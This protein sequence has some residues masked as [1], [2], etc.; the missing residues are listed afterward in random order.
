MLNWK[1]VVFSLWVIAFLGSSCGV[2][3]QLA[4]DETLV[5][6]TEV[7]LEKSTY[8]IKDK[9]LLKSELFSLIKQKPNKR[10]LLLFRTGVS[11]YYHTDE[12]QDT[13]NWKNFLRNNL[14]ETPAIYSEKITKTTTKSME[15]YLKQKGYFDAVVEA[16]EKHSY[17]HKETTVSYHVY[18]NKRYSIK[19]IKY[20][21]LDKKLEG[22]LKKLEQNTLL[23][24]GS[25]IDE[26]LYRREVQR[27]T[28]SLRNNGYVYFYP[29]Y[30]QALESDSTNGKT[31]L[32]IDLSVRAP[33]EEEHHQAYTIGK[34]QVYPTF[35]APDLLNYTKDTLIN[36]YLF[37]T[38]N[39]EFPIKP[40]VIID[41]IYLNPGALFRQSNYDKTT[42]QLSNLN[43]Y[44]FVNVKLQKD[45][46]QVG[47]ID[48]I[49][50]LSLAKKHLLGGNADLNNSYNNLTSAESTISY[51]GA[52]LNLNY[53]NRNT[54]GGA[55]MLVSSIEG[56]VEF[57][58][59]QRNRLINSLDFQFKTDLYFPKLLDPY[60]TWKL[61][62]R[63]KFGK[64]R[65]LSDNYYQQL[66]EKARSRIS[67]GY[68]F[69]D[70]IDFY[71][72]NT[73]NF[74]FGYDL[75]PNPRDRYIINQT[76]ID[77]FLPNT[78]ERFEAIAVNNPFLTRSFN[79]QLFTGFLYRD[80][81]FIWNSPINKRRASWQLRFNHELS[82]AEI[83]LVN[84]LANN[85][86][87]AFAINDTRF[88]H[89]TRAEFELRY[90]K[91]FT[92]TQSFAVRFNTG[93]AVPFSGLSQDVP[94]VKQFFLG[95]PNSI[96]AWRIR[97][98]GAGS[99]YDT[100]LNEPPFYQTGDMKLE[101][102]L[103]YRFDLIPYIYMK[104]AFFLDAGNIWTI[105]NDPDRLGSQISTNFLNEIALGGGFGFRF[106]LSYFVLRLDLGY[107]LRTPYLD[108]D[109]RQWQFYKYP[110]YRFSDYFNSKVVNY[111]LALGFPF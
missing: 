46:A 40:Q 66:K 78:R 44:K 5:T 26:Q 60:R 70:Y 13:T 75:Q 61:L 7:V 15:N 72:F 14:A 76:G 102:N 96:R 52:S 62:N 18:P 83:L 31:A 77:F 65:L 105:K 85:L 41:Q 67:L 28:D 108:E 99:F 93:I 27:I 110:N 81:S 91:F 111:N 22:R 36:N 86:S 51:L 90:S 88:A 8:K 80:F 59:S 30:V 38:K 42:E 11:I 58:L 3:K 17:K 68:N 2:K 9:G 109:N 33:V 71:R 104:G 12:P 16:K 107:K 32:D 79:N 10:L 19:N 39:G 94:F 89:Y 21:S 56:G 49:I 4:F 95:G 100:T 64:K 69:Q 6:K 98:L 106:D 20:S 74:K 50:E 37:T 23:K 63:I 87:K 24:S 101:F 35:Y 29:S 1:I 92:D 34:V 47:I 55:E 48:V 45:T 84:Y 53:R 82:G 103:E 43:T 25:P 73:F 54:F 57:N 97:E